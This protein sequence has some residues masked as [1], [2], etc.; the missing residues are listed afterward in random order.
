[1]CLSVFLDF[2]W[3]IIPSMGLLKKS[4]SLRQGYGGQASGS[5]PAEAASCRQVALLLYSRIEGTFRAPKGL[6]PCWAD[7]FEQPF[8]L[9]VFVFPGASMGHGPE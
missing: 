2:P 7:F 8:F 9:I 4:A 5:K 1:M 3:G 6:R